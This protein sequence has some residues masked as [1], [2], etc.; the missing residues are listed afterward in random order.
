[1]TRADH[2]VKE[3]PSG[4]FFAGSDDDD[5]DAPM[6]PPQSPSAT[7]STRGSSPPTDLFLPGSDDEAAIPESPMPL[8]RKIL[9]LDEEDS[10]VFPFDI[11]ATSVHTLDDVPIKP[12]SPVPQTKDP[13]PKSN[14]R[15]KKRRLS[16]P[17]TTSASDDFPPTYLGEVL[18]PNAWSNVSGKGYVACN[19]PIRVYRDNENENGN[20]GSS[21]TAAVKGKKGAGQ[22]QL[23]LSAML[24][25]QP[26]K[27]NNK[28]KK[29]DTI[30]RLLNS[31]GT[32]RFIPR[33]RPRDV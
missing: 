2:L 14:T 12:L 16:P 19:D 9:I 28:K 10:I 7:I 4:L 13:T 24:K 25:P 15:A 26:S 30:V 23:S 21:K 17:R 8:K 5:V 27:P 33:P 32:G 6:E 1:M 29:E 3:P 11:G 20:S 22:K 31:H 18:V